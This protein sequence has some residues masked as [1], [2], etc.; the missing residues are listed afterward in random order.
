[1][2][3]VDGDDHDDLHS[4]P[5]EKSKMMATT[6]SDPG[7]ESEVSPY[8]QAPTIKITKAT[9]EEDLDK[10]L[11]QMC[12]NERE[13]IYQISRDHPP[14]GPRDV[15]LENIS[16]YLLRCGAPAEII[17]FNILKQVVDNMNIS[18]DTR[19]VVFVIRFFISQSAN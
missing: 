15:R 5:E 17:D 12:N 1:M 8:D 2:S 3:V 10:I 9:P 13:R 4:F 19:Y 14:E 11:S 18:K 7:I 6:R 16:I